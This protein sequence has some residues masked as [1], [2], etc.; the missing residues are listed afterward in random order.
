MAIA[1]NFAY[2]QTKTINVGH[3]DGGDSLARETSTFS[4]TRYALLTF[5]SAALFRIF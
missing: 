2:V 3:V 1:Y 5:L 4:Q